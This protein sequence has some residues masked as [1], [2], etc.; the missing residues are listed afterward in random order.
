MLAS[1]KPAGHK[2]GYV[3]VV[4]RPNVGKST[5][6]NAML[7]QTVAAES[8]RPQTTQRNQLGILTEPGFQMIFVDT[9]GIHE[10]EH[11]LGE[12]MDRASTTVIQDADIVLVVFDLSERPTPDD[13][14]VAERVAAIQFRAYVLVAL[15]KLDLVDAAR[16]NDRRTDFERLVPSADARLTVSATRGDQVGDLLATLRAHLPP[17]P[18]FF[19]EDQIT[20]RFERDVAA[21]LIRAAGMQLLRDELPHSLAVQVDEYTERGD[22]GALISAVIFV[23]KPSQKGMVIGKDGS[24]I[25]QI[26]TLARAEIESMSGREVFLDLRVKVLPG[27]RN[28]PG[29]LRRLGLASAKGP[30]S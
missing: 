21:D 16:L 12:W 26:G 4:G 11:R 19:P 28:D 23:E 24:M 5:L 9:P 15:N 10:P 13:Q 29:A 18:Q 27:W 6:L 25:R 14:R 3:A 1:Q 30:R 2:S 20:D 8:P 7:G 17:G 22:T